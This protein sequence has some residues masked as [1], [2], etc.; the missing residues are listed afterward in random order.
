MKHVK[1]QVHKKKII[2]KAEVVSPEKEYGPQKQLMKDS[3]YYLLSYKKNSTITK[4]RRN[5][6]YT[7]S[8]LKV[9]R[10]CG[11]YVK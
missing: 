10:Y 9:N 6:Q 3:D 7:C 5:I 11:K 4:G 1:Y 8:I 2:R